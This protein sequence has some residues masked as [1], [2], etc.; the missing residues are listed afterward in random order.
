MSLAVTRTGGIGRPT[1]R[2]RAVATGCEPEVAIA[3]R[4]PAV[5]INSRAP[6]I[7]VM[8]PVPA[9]SYSSMTTSSSSASRWGANSRSTSRP[10]RPCSRGSIVSKTTPRSPAQR[11][12][13]ASTTGV[14]STRTPSKSESS[15]TSGPV[16]RAGQ[17]LDE[18]L[19][20]PGRPALVGVAVR[21]VG[22]DH[23]VAVIPVELRLRVQ[24]ERAA[25]LLG[26]VGEDVGARVAAVGAGVAEDDHGRA[27]VQVV[28]DHLQ[29]L[30]PHAAVVGVAAHVGHA[31]V[32]GDRVRDRL[33][34]A[35]AVEDVG[36][37]GDALDE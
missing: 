35:L 26:D 33:E 3:H 37:L 10:G 19:E 21:L 6:G 15:G 17:R 11:L 27:R 16:R 23:G 13:A 32:L 30:A 7:T 34:R 5:S 20:L 18:V 14:E 2:I 25:G 31:G 12:Q 4:G 29:E 28:L 36:D 8:S 24:P 22:G 9:S 1:A